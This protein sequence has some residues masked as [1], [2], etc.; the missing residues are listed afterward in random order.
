MSR[1]EVMSGIERWTRADREAMNTNRSRP[2][3]GYM[4]D[5][6]GPAMR[7]WNVALRDPYQ[8][9]QQ[10][11]IP[12][13]ARMVD[14]TQNVGWIAG[15]IAQGVANCVGSGLKLNVQPDFDALRLDPDRAA[16]W[17]KRAENRF[18]VW[19]NRPLECDV[20]GRRKFGQMQAAAYR[21]WYA[22]GEIV[23][24]LPW[25]ERVGGMYGTKVRL[26]PPHFLSQKTEGMSRLVQGVYMNA[27]NFPVAYLFELPD[28]IMGK[29][30]VTVNARD[31]EGRISVAHIFDGAIG[32]IRGISC[33]VPVIQVA[34]QYDQLANATLTKSIV[35]SLFA[36]SVKSD[37]PTDDVLNGLQ[38]P[39]EQARCLE[40]GISPLDAWLAY[41]SAFYKETPI[42]LGIPGRIA[43]LAP[44][45]ELEFHTPQSVDTNYKDFA[46]DLL[47]EMSRCAGITYE[48]WTGDYAG[49]TFSSIRFA[50]DSI[51][52][53]VKYRRDNIVSPFCQAAYENWLEE[54]IDRGGPLALPGG[55]DQFL[56]NKAGICN[57]QWTGSPKPTPDELKTANAEQIEL[58]LGIASEYDLCERHGRNYDDVCSERARAKEVRDNYG[59]DDPT[60]GS[61]KP[62][63]AVTAEEPPKQLQA[64]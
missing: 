49:V 4:R 47:R 7:K 26:V 11:Y 31:R 36:A 23:A 51:W 34:R 21:D 39:E 44:G 30:N 48:E 3:A 42:D 24:E 9:V 32:H 61:G 57:A 64:A 5:G 29:R 25:R 43:S 20:E 41:Q 63:E 62:A 17:A 12:A 35:L 58:G 53:I 10:A 27:D 38:V 1:F 2:Q 14:L 22:F 54:E 46:R 19:S 50:T 59:L 16:E 8:D 45:S 13:A 37:Q 40:A 6:R 55:M 33:M 60:L 52:R 15:G 18:A 28:P 56:A